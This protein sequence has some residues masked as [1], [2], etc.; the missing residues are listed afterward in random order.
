MI[1]QTYVVTWHVQRGHLRARSYST[2]L[3]V[4]DLQ[5]R[6]CLAVRKPGPGCRRIFL[7][8][9]LARSPFLHR[10]AHC[11]RSVA[12][13]HSA[14][15]ALHQLEEGTETSGLRWRNDVP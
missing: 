14:R 12:H 2:G 1:R 4:A 7:L 3:D 10:G 6:R 5:L 13:L 11:R 8:V 9:C 15:L